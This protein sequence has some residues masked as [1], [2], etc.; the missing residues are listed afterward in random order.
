MADAWYVGRNGER[1]GPFSETELREQAAR[2]QIG[3][4]DLVWREGMP[5]WVAA[6]TI[7]GLLPAAPATNPY[8]AP[9]TSDLSI[10]VFQ[11]ASGETFQYAE[12]MPRVGA[13]LLDGLFVG[14]MG[15]IP[16]LGM[17]VVFIAAVGNDSDAQAAAGA[18]AN[19]CSQIVGIVIGVIYYV[20][21]ETSAKQGTWGKQI[22]GIRVTDLEG[23]RITVGRALGRYFAKWITGCTC[24]IGMLMPLWTEK[25]QTLHDMISG[26]LALKR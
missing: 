21:L 26:C 14:L 15:C 7:P 22:V 16:A 2:G 19:C 6:S 12:Y 5:A 8:A 24:G 4:A 20:T 13:A 3:P 11:G 10:P 23:R 17:S 9:A 1:S 18:V 25:K